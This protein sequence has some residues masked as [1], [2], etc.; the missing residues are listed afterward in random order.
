MCSARAGLPGPGGNLPGI[1]TRRF[2]VCGLLVFAA[3]CLLQ[4]FLRLCYCLL[5]VVCVVFSTWALSIVYYD[6]ISYDSI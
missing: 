3:Y 2:L 5:I 1:Q 6:M 4:L